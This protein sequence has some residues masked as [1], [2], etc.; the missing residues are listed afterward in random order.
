MKRKI[1]YYWVSKDGTPMA[2]SEALASFSPRGQ[3]EPRYREVLPRYA[4]PEDRAT[5]RRQAL[6][7]LRSRIRTTERNIDSIPG[8]VLEDTS[9]AAKLGK[10]GAFGIERKYVE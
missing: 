5:Y 3:D 1:L 7:L 10:H 2:Y 6:S 8:S 9:V 4:P